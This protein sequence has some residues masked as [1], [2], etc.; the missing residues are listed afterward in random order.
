M[1]LSQNIVY[2]KAEQALFEA[3]G[4]KDLLS[5]LEPWGLYRMASEKAF[6]NNL[7]G[8][9]IEA[10]RRGTKALLVDCKPYRMTPE[11]DSLVTF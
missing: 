9:E 11:F 8:P 7:Q 5:H 10:L 3:L 4:F 1:S 2:S 6:V